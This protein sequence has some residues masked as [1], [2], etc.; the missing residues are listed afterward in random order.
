MPFLDIFGG[1]VSSLERMLFETVLPIQPK[2]KTLPPQCPF[3]PGQETCENQP[4]CPFAP[5]R[6]AH[7]IGPC[8]ISTSHLTLPWKNKQVMPMDGNPFCHAW[9][10]HVI[11]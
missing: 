8:R 2:R 1:Y 10:V 5:P 11:S 6:I 3:Q 4:A 7:Q 9:P